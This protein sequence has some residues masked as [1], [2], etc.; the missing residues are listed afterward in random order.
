MTILPRSIIAIGEHVRRP[1]PLCG[2]SGSSRRLFSFRY[3]SGYGKADGNATVERPQRRETRRLE[4]LGSATRNAGTL[5]VDPASP[6]PWQRSN[7]HG[8]TRRANRTFAE[9]TFQTSCQPA[10]AGPRAER[11]VRSTHGREN[12]SARFIDRSARP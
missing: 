7:L 8:S 4:R 9:R 1:N 12:L 11:H 2:R 3:G 6:P 5:I 10:F